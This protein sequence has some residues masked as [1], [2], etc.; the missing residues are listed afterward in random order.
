[1]T[2]TAVVAVFIF[3]FLTA[4]IWHFSVGEVAEAYS[5]PQ[6]IV[7]ESDAWRSSVRVEI[8]WDESQPESERYYAVG[9]ESKDA[10]TGIQK[11]Y[12][13]PFDVT[14]EDV[15]VRAY[16]KDADGRSTYVRKEIKN[17]DKMPPNAA[18][19]EESALL[20]VD[21]RSESPFFLKIVLRDD[22]SGI[23]RGY[24]EEYGDELTK[25]TDGGANMYG[26]DVTPYLGM[27]VTVVAVDNAGN[28]STY[29]VSL[30]GFEEDIIRRYSQ[31][32]ASLDLDEY[33]DDG[34][35]AI[36][37]A[38][39]R[40]SRELTARS[41]DNS[42]ALALA[43]EVDNA[44]VG[45]I[46]VTKVVTEKPD[47]DMILDFGV[48]ADITSVD[49]KKGE[50]LTL[51]VGKSTIAGSD[52]VKNAL[53]NASGYKSNKVYAFAL[54]LKNGSEDVA[55]KSKIPV[56]VSIPSAVF[57]VQVYAVTADGAINQLSC[58]IDESAGTVTFYVDSF[59]D[60]AM[61]GITPYVA[62]RGK[63]IEI[64]GKFYSL[65]LI[66]TAVGIVVGVSVGG[67]VITFI[68]LNIVKK[69]KQRR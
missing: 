34:R 61:I 55:L 59:G 47:N 6:I 54:S 26:V 12:T 48:N 43:R 52:A 64:D 68:V 45:K 17:V 58:T 22:R 38:F 57:P 16:Y 13:M 51:S 9:V 37:E 53:V 19:M 36:D 5:A 42:T 56:T 62:E 66:L 50:N 40:L 20:T 23:A 69:K 28:R 7:D 41:T 33:S 67:G 25:Q 3:T 21:L 10:F 35:A 32:Y 2:V 30:G 15:C 11:K 24:L 60:F 1:M 27:K 18:T 8:V 31:K 65:K 63:G 39:D 4:S 44:I 46:T 14:D 29:G 49:V